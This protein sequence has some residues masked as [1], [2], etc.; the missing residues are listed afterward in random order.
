MGFVPMGLGEGREVG[1]PCWGLLLGAAVLGL[2]IAFVTVSIHA[3][4]RI[5]ADPVES[6][7]YE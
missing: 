5:S 6:L 7:R 3:L 4:R 2:G 1:D